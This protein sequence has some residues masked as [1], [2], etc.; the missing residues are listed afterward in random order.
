MPVSGRLLRQGR[1]WDF[2]DIAD[3]L[4][5]RLRAVPPAFGDLIA[6]PRGDHD[7]QEEPVEIPD[8]AAAI[9]AAVLIPI[10][11]HP[12]EPTVLLTQRATALRNH[13]G[14]VAFPGG[15]VDAVDGSPLI[16][17]LREA[18]EEIGLAR[19]RVRTVGYLDA[20][21]TGTGYRVVPVVGLVEPPLALTINPHEVDE[22]FETPL[23]FLMDPANHQR[24]AREWKGRHRTYYAMPHD[25][26]YIWGATAGMIRNLYE[27]LA[28]GEF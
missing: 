26:H 14:Q 13:S 21:L 6:R 7:L 17:A 24:H 2:S 5:G 4:A 20:Y 23:S 28:T 10:V 19:D 9:A 16:A 25:G 1:D 22:A 18:E 15:R 11:L 3:V 12:G 27:R 8:E